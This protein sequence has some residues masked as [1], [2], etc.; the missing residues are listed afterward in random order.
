MVF[1][2]TIFLVVIWGTLHGLILL[3]AFL[4]ALPARWLELNCYSMFFQRISTSMG[5][6]SKNCTKTP[7]QFIMSN[8]TN[9]REKF[10]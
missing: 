3:L 5:E 9:E 1:V 8:I 6:D 7:S 10:K 4:A 2:K